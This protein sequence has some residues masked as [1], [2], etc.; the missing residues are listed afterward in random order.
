MGDIA[1]KFPGGTD[2]QVKGFGTSSGTNP[3]CQYQRKRLPLPVFDLPL[4]VVLVPVPEVLPRSRSG[5]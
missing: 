5:W 4:Y 3:S 2:A 1:L